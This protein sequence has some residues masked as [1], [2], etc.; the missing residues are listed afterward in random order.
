M[1]VPSNPLSDGQTEGLVPRFSVGA[2][3]HDNR[4]VAPI[5][6]AETTREAETTDASEFLWNT[7]QYLN[8]YARFADTKAGFAG[9]LAAA[10]LGC[11]YA[12][13]SQ[14]PIFQ[15]PSVPWN[16]KMTFGLVAAVLLVLS[17]ALAAWTVRPR[18]RS[19]QIQGFIYWGNLAA[20]S[21]HLE[22]A[23]AFRGHDAR[24][25][26]DQLLHHNFD[27]AT[28]VCVPKY[29][30]VSLCISALALGAAFTGAG[31]LFR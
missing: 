31:L 9:A 5:V 3:V 1:T 19:T 21:D 11:L 17:I 25:L 29:R 8:E 15:N 16:W 6:P 28:Q 23:R 12:E 10:L 27:I 22:L 24:S 13:K 20:F 14:F 2:A 7:H 4:A 18:L 30:A 26:N